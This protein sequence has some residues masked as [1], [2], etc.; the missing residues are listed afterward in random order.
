MPGS[1][2][3]PRNR[4]SQFQ[5]GADG[6]APQRLGVGFGS[7]GF[8][9]TTLA[10]ST[11]ETQLVLPT[12][13][14]KIKGFSFAVGTSFGASDLVKLELDNQVFI[15]SQ[16]ANSLVQNGE[17]WFY[18]YERNYYNNSVFKISVTTAAATNVNFI[19]YYES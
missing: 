19:V 1:Q 5:T 10:G 6:R 3:A 14:R 15:E 16:A 17:L 8:N 4:T 12:I 13:A 11:V 2:L 18:P 9:I 7:I